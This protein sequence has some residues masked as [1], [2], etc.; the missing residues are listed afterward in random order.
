MGFIPRMIFWLALA[1]LIPAWASA[2][3]ML[4]NDHP[5]AG[6]IWDMRHRT[7][8]DES[9]LL[10]RSNVADVLLLGETHDNPLHHELQQK[11]LIARIAASGES[12]FK[13][14]L[15]MEQ[16][17][18]DDQQALN[19]ELNKSDRETAL[20][21]IT[22]LISFADKNVYQPL[23]SLA[24]E[25]NLPI[26]AAN[27]PGKLA[28]PVIWRGFA[29]YDAAELKRLAVAEVWSDERQ[30]YLSENMGGAHC[31]KLRDELR[32]GL[33]R[34]Q[35]LRDALMVDSAISS[36]ENGI[37]A[38]VGSSHARR[39]IGLPLY[40]AARAPTSKIFSVGFIEVNPN[41]TDPLAYEANSATGEIPY[42][43]IWFTPRKERANPC[44]ELEET[45]GTQL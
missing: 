31:G 27:I 41:V 12:Q 30:K 26:I 35:R 13:P 2:G 1:C 15:M 29:A 16:F 37:I 45:K 6:R 7:F 18:I 4:L 38:I 36:I 39:D 42:D 8:I 24:V 19:Q 20:N 21:H 34:G 17:N 40:F 22:D 14:A 25:N 11:L 44:A 23:V 5:L 10:S 33:T 9:A 32:E 43:A 28:Q 3:N